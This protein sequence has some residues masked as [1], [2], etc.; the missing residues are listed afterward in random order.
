MRYLLDT[1]IVIWAS[2]NSPSLPKLAAQL[3]Q[4]PT[5]ELY[6]S[7]AVIWEASIKGSAKMGISAEMLN[8][9]AKMAGY[10]ILNIN[11]DHA[12]RVQTLPTHYCDPFDRIMLAQALCEGMQ[13]VTADGKLALYGTGIYAV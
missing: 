2:L 7:S 11:A 3:L 9:S 5:A 1:D 12:I 13:L 6:I 4:D 8:K 10:K